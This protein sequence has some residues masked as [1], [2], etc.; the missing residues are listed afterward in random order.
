MSSRSKAPSRVSRLSDE[1]VLRQI[2]DA[3]G[4]Q[5]QGAEAPVAEPRA[6][7]ARYERK[8]GVI[9]VELN[10]GAFFGFPARLG[11]GLAGASARDLAQVEVS[12]SGEA[13]HWPALDVDLRV[14]ALVHGIF[15]TRAWM[16]EL[17]RAG[18]R[19]RSA[20]KARAARRNGARGGRPR[21]TA[22]PAGR[23][24]S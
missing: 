4:A 3:R 5:E 10:S 19:S 7:A 12:P 8:R 16:R 11:Q 9:I 1:D 18:G 6:T 14:P 15:G 23:P 13:L 21:Q 17:A 20:A 22:K 2:R 24:S